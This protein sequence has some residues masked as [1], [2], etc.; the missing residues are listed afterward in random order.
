MVKYLLRA[1]ALCLLLALGSCT[2]SNGTGLPLPGFGDT[3]D[4]VIAVAGIADGGTVS[5]T[6]ALSGAATDNV[7]VTAFTLSIDGTQVASSA[8]GALAYSWVT[9][10]ATNGAH[11][12]VF[13]A[14]DAAGN[15]AAT[16]INTTVNNGGG[17]GGGGGATGT[18]SGTVL[19]PNGTDPVSAALVFVMGAGVSA[20]GDPPDEPH[21][22]FTYS[23][24][25]GQFTLQD[26]PVGARAIKI[27]KG[28]FFKVLNITVVEGANAL[29]AT[30]TSLPSGAEGGAGDMLVVT[31]H[32]DRIEN[33]LAKLGLGTVNETFN[34]LEIGTETFE[35]V[36]ATNE[37]SDAGYDNFDEWWPVAANWDDYRTIFFNCGND[38]DEAFLADPVAVA[39]LKAWVQAGGRLYCT[40]WSYN[41][42]EQIWPD[43]VDFASFGD[44]AGLSTTPEDLHLAKTGTSIESLSCHMED[45]TLASWMSGI[46]AA[47]AGDTFPT[48]DWL[49]AW[50][51]MDAVAPTGVKVW[52]TGTPPGEVSARPMTITF[53]EGAGTVLFSSYHTEETASADIRPQERVLQYLIFEVL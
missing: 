9:T 51:P 44:P 24:A 53:Q 22:V 3:F 21:G 27:Q 45:A 13:T 4:P 52:A 20:V 5:G 18:V 32:Y 8:N 42:I 7:G 49:P 23:G 48:V 26:V 33:V 2:T 16:T 35:M 6:L 41:F 31:G 39:R 46:G 34:T 1:A 29:T 30:E 15:S 50:V 36:D 25:N 19:A 38:Y 43:K 28:A 40:D 37:L 12:L 11:A 47:S 17:G 14:S 10:G